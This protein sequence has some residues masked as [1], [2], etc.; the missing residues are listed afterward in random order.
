MHD[1]LAEQV[2]PE[3]LG[4]VLDLVPD[5]WLL[6]DPT[7]PDPKAPAGRGQR[8]AGVRRLSCW[9]GWRP[10]TELAAVSGPNAGE[11]R[12]PF[13][14]AV[15]RAVPRVDRGEFV[16][17]GVILYCQPLDF[18]QAAVVVDDVRLRALAAD[19]DLEAVLTSA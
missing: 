8:P 19:V 18:L 16:N 2:T 7:R 11:V 4:G 14:Y 17:V 12:R 1:E 9:P 5:A 3:L 15:L 13:T 10:R 6:P